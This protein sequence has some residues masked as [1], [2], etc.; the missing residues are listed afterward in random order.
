MKITLIPVSEENKEA[1]LR[2]STR[3]DQPAGFCRFV[4]D[5]QNGDKDE[6]YRLWRFMID[7]SQQDK[8]YGQ[9]ALLFQ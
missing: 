2:L 5:P 8:G 6:H 1:V 4:F 7:K 3:E 9:A